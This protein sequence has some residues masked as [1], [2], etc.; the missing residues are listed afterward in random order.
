MDQRKVKEKKVNNMPAKSNFS[1]KNC[2]ECGNIIV[3]KL[4]RDIERKK[5]CSRKCGGL[6]QSKQR[7]KDHMCKMWAKCNTPE[8]NAKKAHKGDAH[9]RYIK[10]RNQVKSK[11]PKYENSQWTRAIF[12]RDDFTCQACNQ[13]GGK[14]QAD[15]IK[16]YCLCSEEEKWSLNNGRTLCISCHK[17]TDTYGIKLVHQLKKEKKNARIQ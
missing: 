5:F 7:S 8:A 10:D 15:H 17:K 2:L 12:E 1:H 11:R 3:I 6:Y 9:P 16:P 13:R 14:L 4:K